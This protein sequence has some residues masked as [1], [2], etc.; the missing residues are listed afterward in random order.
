[1]A[2]Q[3]RIRLG[4]L[5]LWDGS[6]ASLSELRIRCCH[7]LWCRLQ[8]RLG[9]GIAVALAWSGSCGFDSTP[10]LGTSTCNEYSPEKQKK[11]K[12]KKK[13]GGKDTINEKKSKKHSTKGKKKD[14]V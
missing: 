8:M 7:E 9:S 12:K 13:K 4:I 14:G 10:C 2:Q 3:K 5:R 1:M 6:L 11:K